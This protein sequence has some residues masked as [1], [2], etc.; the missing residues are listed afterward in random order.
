MAWQN[1]EDK[2]L[3][4]EMLIKGR[5]AKEIHDAL[6]KRCDLFSIYD[7]SKKLRSEGLLTKKIGGGG[8]RKRKPISQEWQVDR[9]SP[10]NS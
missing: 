8:T 6:A 7:L 9:G 4:R 3:G 5:S 2:A 1:E 10:Q